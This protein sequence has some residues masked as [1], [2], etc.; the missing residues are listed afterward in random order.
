MINETRGIQIQGEKVRQ[1]LLNRPTIPETRS[2]CIHAMSADKATKAK[3]VLDV[4]WIMW[5][6]KII[7]KNMWSWMVC[8]NQA[9]HRLAPWRKCQS[10]KSESQQMRWIHVSENEM[11]DEYVASIIAE[12]VCTDVNADSSVPFCS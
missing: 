1:L 10:M 12:A 4:L 3:P 7:D 2:G 11:V 8:S 5:Y 6:H 9:M